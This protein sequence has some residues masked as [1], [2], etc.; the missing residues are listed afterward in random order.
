MDDLKQ[1]GISAEEL[2][3]K[4]EIVKATSKVVKTES[5]LE[6][7]TRFSLGRD[8]FYGKQHIENIMEVET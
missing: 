8:K 2:S 4:T 6:E 7:C 3:N 5:G 1:L